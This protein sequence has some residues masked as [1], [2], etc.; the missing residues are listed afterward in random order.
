MNEQTVFVIDDDPTA[1]ESIMALAKSMGVAAKEFDS[2]E[3]FLEFYQGEPG[4]LVTDY[5]MPGMNGLELQETLI[6][7]GSAIPTIIVTAFARTSL[8]VQAIKN[9]AVTMLDKPYDE[10]KL[11]Q[12][13]RTALTQ[14][15][16]YRERHQ[17]ELEARERLGSLNEK[18]KSV[19]KLL[20]EGSSNKAMAQ[21]L[22]VSLRTIENRR[23]KIFM[24]MGVDS[25]AEL[26]AMVLRVRYAPQVGSPSNNSSEAGTSRTAP[27]Q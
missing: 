22:S 19:L 18:E 9:G 24:K 15:D 6:E 20:L 1:R 16:E 27:A 14:D 8:T 21:E 11:W 12:A 2:A 10:D 23:R 13:I 26:V 17:A 25:V 3:A 7:Q 4:C 5:R